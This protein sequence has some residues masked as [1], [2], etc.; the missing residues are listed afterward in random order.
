MAGNIIFFLCKSLL[1]LQESWRLLC[2]TWR[3]FALRRQRR[4]VIQRVVHYNRAKYVYI[5]WLPHSFSVSLSDGSIPRTQHALVIQLFTWRN[6]TR[7]GQWKVVV[8]IIAAS[9]LLVSGGQ[10]GAAGEEGWS[11]NHRTNIDRLASYLSR[12]RVG[13]PAVGVGGARVL[14]RGSSSAALLFGWRRQAMTMA[15]LENNFSRPLPRPNVIGV[16]GESCTWVNGQCFIFVIR[17]CRCWSF[18]SRV[19][20]RLWVMWTLAGWIW[21][22]LLSATDVINGEARSRSWK[23]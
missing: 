22:S 15:A 14:P 3:C 10:F 1:F 17:W 9:F 23:S 18:S 21:L 16:V 11:R 12:P 4:T 2:S 13:S 8:L 7:I 19:R 5:I 6:E 20:Y